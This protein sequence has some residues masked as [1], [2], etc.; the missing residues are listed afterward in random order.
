MTRIE[1][2]ITW[3]ERLSAFEWNLPFES[4]YLQVAL[5]VKRMYA[6]VCVIHPEKMADH[7][8]DY[9]VGKDGEI[10]AK[11]GIVDL[12]EDIFMEYVATQSNVIDYLLAYYC[13]SPY[14]DVKFENLAFDEFDDECK[15]SLLDFCKRRKNMFE[16]RL[17]SSL[18]VCEKDHPLK[19]YHDLFSEGD[20]CAVD[21]CVILKSKL[22]P[23]LKNAEDHITKEDAYLCE[24]V[25][26]CEKVLIRWLAGYSFSITDST[27]EYAY[28][29]SCD[30]SGS[31]C[32]YGYGY[33]VLDHRLE[34]L[35]AGEIIDR[36]ILE[37]DKK[38]SFLPEHIR[39]LKE[40]G[41]G[42]ET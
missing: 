21:D 11:N 38:Y 28:Y 29:F 20:D 7:T 18:E 31:W 24:M 41:N 17:I 9:L 4:N 30:D 2:L 1:Q 33:G 37:L 26:R 25:N 12:E 15:M 14:W 19:D 34:I 42:G 40:T 5:Y 39:D 10:Y 32:S 6:L 13:K 16:D 36:C 22:I 27:Y 8:A 35:I 3:F 23:Y